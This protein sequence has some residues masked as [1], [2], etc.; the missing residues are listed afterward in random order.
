MTSVTS[1]TS[2][3]DVDHLEIRSIAGLPEVTPGDE[4]ADLI[5]P[6]LDSLTWSDGSRGLRDG[7]IVAVSSKVVSKAEGRVVQA[8]DRE[9]AITAETVRVVATRESAAG[10]LH[11]VENPQGLVMA[12]AGVDSSNTPAGTVLLLP[13]DPDRSA[14]RLRMALAA[15]LGVTLATIITDTIGRPWRQGLTD[16]AIGAA[17][18]RVLDDLRGQVDASGRPLTVTVVAIADEVAAATELV[19]GKAVGRPAAVVRGL[20][21]YVT[22]DDGAGARSTQRPPEEDLFSLG[23]AEAFAAGWAAARA[24]ADAVPGEQ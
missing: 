17:G 19:R 16:I 12:A 18:L 21:R 23:T 22:V 24:A 5:A 2:G 3:D 11:I 6:L 4:L 9:A 14:R 7:D 1:V 8:A 15:R 10:T 13:L 20:G